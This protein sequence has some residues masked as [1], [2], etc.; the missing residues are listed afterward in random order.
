MQHTSPWVCGSRAYRSAW[1][2]AMGRGRLWRP[3]ADPVRP[4][5]RAADGGGAVAF[6]QDVQLRPAGGPRQ[7]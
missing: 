4:E 1:A 3:R 6:L 7:L 2:G 5:E